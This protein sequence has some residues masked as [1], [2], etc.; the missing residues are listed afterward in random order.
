MPFPTVH[1]SLFETLQA[2]GYEEPTPVQARVLDPELAGQDLLVSAQTG[3]GKTV[4]YG[5]AMAPTLL[6]AAEKFGAPSRPLALVVAPTRELALQVRSELGWLYARTGAR[7]ATCVG[8]MDQRRER[9]MLAQG[10]HIVVGTPGRLCDHLERGN[11]EL[12]ALRVLVLDE[13]DEMLDLGFREDLERLLETTPSERRTL[14]FSATIPKGILHIAKQYQR[15]ARRVATV[16]DKEP[17]GDIEYRVFQMAPSDREHAI[18]NVLRYFGA[19][20]A[21]VFCRTREAVKHLHGNLLER[22]FSVVA[23]SGEFTQNERSRAL[24]ALRDGH[25]RVCVATDVAARGLD[26]PALGLVVHADLPNDRQ[27]LVHRSG[28]TARAGRKGVAALLVSHAERRRAERLLAE[29]NI[30]PPWAPPP[31]ADAVRARDQERLVSELAALA[32]DLT[33]EDLV[34]GKALLAQR[35]PEEVAATLVRRERNHLPAPEELTVE[36]LRPAPP[37]R[38]RAQDAGEAEQH[39]RPR[40][41]QGGYAWYRLNVGHDKNADPRWLLPFICRRGHITKLDVG[42]IRIEEHHT[43]FEIVERVVARFQAAIRRPDPI[44]KGLVIE[45]AMQGEARPGRWPAQRAAR[46]RVRPRE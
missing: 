23:L 43:D 15:D 20:G 2:R 36:S 18:V 27:A 31:S 24:Q 10:V 26:L 7:I 42:K 37:P 30:R 41:K 1:P 4:A 45:P 39:R 35:T 46:S 16:S 33:D 25:A 11:L 38:W 5:L 19:R 12:S 13:A 14:L 6:E 22:G 3:S 34:A 32:E 29:A 28:R 40:G 17:H 21:L 9:A 44:D 8:G